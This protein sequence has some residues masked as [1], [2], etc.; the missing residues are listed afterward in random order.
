MSKRT[1]TPEQ[2]RKRLSEPMGE[3]GA[4]FVCDLLGLDHAHAA[5]FASQPRGRALVHFE[6]LN[7]LP[8]H[9]RERDLME[10]NGSDGRVKA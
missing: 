5:W 1:E 2:R 4:T 6:Q 9:M 10:R 8:P 3:R 7:Q